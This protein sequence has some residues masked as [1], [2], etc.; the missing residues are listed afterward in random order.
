MNER[1]RV[2]Y[3]RIGHIL[4]RLI[5][6]LRN[7]PIIDYIMKKVLFVE[8]FKTNYKFKDHLCLQID[9]QEKQKASIDFFLLTPSISTL[10]TD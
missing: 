6:K 7:L 9:G 4:K 5:L 8:S 10:R 1:L 2:T 3:Q